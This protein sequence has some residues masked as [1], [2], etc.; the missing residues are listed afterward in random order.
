MRRSLRS[1]IQKNV[2]EN[3]FTLS[4]LSELSGI[5]TGHLSEMLNSNPLRAITVSQLDAMATAFAYVNGK[6]DRDETVFRF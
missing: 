4:K 2:K 6:T 5:S 3:G 1:E